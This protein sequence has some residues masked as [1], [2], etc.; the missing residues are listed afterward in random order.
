MKIEVNFDY[1]RELNP[2]R[3]IWEAKGSADPDSRSKRLQ[4]MHQLLWSKRLPNGAAFDL[5]LAERGQLVWQA[6]RLSSD[7]ITNSYIADSRLREIVAQERALAEQLFRAGSRISAFILFPANR[8]NGQNTI[9]GARGMN[10]KIADRMDL[11][12]ECIR[13][14]YFRLESPLSDVLSR[15]ASF[16]SLF[17]TFDKYVEFWF[18]NDLLNPQNQVQFFLPFDNFKRNALPVD[19]NEYAQIANHTLRFLASRQKRIESYLKKS[20]FSLADGE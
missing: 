19:A 10:A 7:S 13:R 14:H 11:T 9:N 4:R 1:W 8:I 16:F 2:D 17:E 6:F 3:N 15:Y 12:L 5:E 20:R 18:L